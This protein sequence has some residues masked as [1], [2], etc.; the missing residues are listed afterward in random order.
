MITSL[1]WL[2]IQ[3]GSLLTL[4]AARHTTVSCSA[5]CLHM[6]SVPFQQ[7]CSLA[8]EAP[9]LLLQVV[10]SSSAWDFPFVL[11]EFSVKIPAGPLLQPA[12]MTAQPSSISTG[13]L[14]NLVPSAKLISK[15][16]IAFSR[17]LIDMS[18]KVLRQTSVVLP[19]I[20][21]FQAVYDPLTI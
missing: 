17:L 12:W 7:S 18:S 3:P 15:H 16:Y 11:V 19:C 1:D 5:C 6:N 14:H 13:P 2:F 9:A 10:L 21:S 4:F 20:T 8:S